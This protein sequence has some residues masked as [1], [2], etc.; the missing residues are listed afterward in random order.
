MDN[1]VSA[2]KRGQLFLTAVP[3]AGDSSWA[4]GTA[5]LTTTDLQ[6][7]VRLV[8]MQL[9]KVKW[10]QLHVINASDDDGIWFFWMPDISGEVQIESSRGT[11]PFLIETDKHDDRFI[12]RSPQET[13]DR[14]IEWLQLPGGR[15]ESPWHS[16]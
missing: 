8:E 3:H 6:E 9:P 4:K 7:V 11:C 15:A 16:R 14:I 10:E 12:S 5:P 13:A 1:P 2:R